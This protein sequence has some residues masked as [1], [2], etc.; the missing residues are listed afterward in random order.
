MNEYNFIN[1]VLTACAAANA[2]EH[3][4]VIVAPYALCRAAVKAY[5]AE[6]DRLFPLREDDWDQRIQWADRVN[7][8][9]EEVDR[10]CEDND[11]DNKE[12]IM[13]IRS[14]Q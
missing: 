13:T 5:E 14:W 9:C 7:S 10:Y 1:K 12:F 4:D 2:I 8:L 6:L 11:I 3:D